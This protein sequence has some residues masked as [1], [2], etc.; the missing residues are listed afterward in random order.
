M[1]SEKSSPRGHPAVVH[2]PLWRF[3]TVALSSDDTDEWATD[4]EKGSGLLHAE[5]MGSTGA[6]LDFD[7]I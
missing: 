2:R 4:V 3:R 6:M 7:P 5:R 1:L